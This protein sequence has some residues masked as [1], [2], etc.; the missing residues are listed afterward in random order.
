MFTGQAISAKIVCREVRRVV[1]G[2]NKQGTVRKP[3][4]CEKNPARAFN[5]HWR[6]SHASLKS[7]DKKQEQGSSREG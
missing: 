2:S 4:P 5:D 6:T 3:Q 1:E 7:R